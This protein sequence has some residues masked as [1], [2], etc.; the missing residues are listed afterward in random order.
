MNLSL[1]HLPLAEL[2]IEDKTA[3]RPIA[4]YA[5]LERRLLADDY[6]VSV[7]PKD[8][9]R[10]DH[11]LLLNLAF[12]E[13][14]QGGDILTDRSVPADVVCHMAW[15]HVATAALA[16]PGAPLSPEAMLLGESIASAFDLYL[17]GRL[18][19]VA[20]DGDFVGTQLPAM[21]D[22]AEA[23]GVDNDAFEALVGEVTKAPEAAFESLR[24]LI[25]DVSVGLLA[26][27]TA[28]QALAVLV[29]HE[30]RRFGCL[31]HHFE[32]ASW[33]QHARAARAALPADDVTAARAREA[34]A[35]LRA[36]V[37]P[38]AWLEANWLG[39]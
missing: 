39:G 18:L 26:A 37:D 21:A 12:W 5:A 31:L 11:A 10:W 35:A 17:L 20:P 19:V 6:R 29:A 15:H 28:E 25:Y 38:I 13:A 3:M 1:R 33:L 24:A 36:A 23:A 9:A 2:H 8:A 27:E 16:T 34:D 7:L 22:V 30:D 4:I 32:L 14:Q